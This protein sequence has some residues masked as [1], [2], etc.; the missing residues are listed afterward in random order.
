MNVDELL[1][2]AWRAV[3]QS[4]VPEHLQEVAFKEAVDYLTGKR[5][6]RPQQ[7]QAPAPPSG[8]GGGGGGGGESSGN[9]NSTQKPGGAMGDKSASDFFFSRLADET[10][11]DEADL[12]A[13]LHYDGEK[14][15]IAPPARMLGRSKSEQVKTVA[16]LVAGARHAGLNENPVAT[17]HVR[18]E[19][20]RKNCYDKS[21]FS[22]HVGPLKGVNMSGSDKLLMNPRWHGEFAAAV[23][24]VLGKPADDS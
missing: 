1:S 9:G 2:T 20:T 14:V 11:V 13:A 8:G 5:A 19:C 3:E 21:N 18:D 24:K 23:K 16:S 17:Q 22:K 6:A 4:G 15:I 7:Q 10:G 12:R